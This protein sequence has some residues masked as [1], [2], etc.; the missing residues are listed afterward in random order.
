M[1]PDLSTKMDQDQSCKSGSG[2]ILQKWIRNDSYSAKFTS[3]SQFF[4]NC[5]H[6]ENWEIIYYSVIRPGN[7]RMV[8][9]KIKVWSSLFLNFQTNL[10]LYLYPEKCKKIQPIRVAYH[11]PVNIKFNVPFKIGIK[12]T[13]GTP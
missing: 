13:G 1:D 7:F 3:C 2:L 9:I 10:I 4:Q 11:Y 5:F 8:D 6:A 12:G